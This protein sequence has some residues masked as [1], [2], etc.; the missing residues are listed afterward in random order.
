MRYVYP[1]FNPGYDLGIVRLG[2]PGLGNLLIFYA[3]AIVYAHENDARII[4]PTWP[5]IK[6]GPYIRREKDKRFYGDLFRHKDDEISGL[7]KLFLLLFSRKNITMCDRYM[8]TMKEAGL[9]GKSAMIYSHLIKHNA[10]PEYMRN[11]RG[12]IAV[13]VRLGDFLRVSEAALKNNAE[14]SSTPVYWYADTINKIRA[15]LG[16]N[17]QV[18]VFSDG[19]DEE[20]K[21]LLELEN[22]ERIFC[23]NALNDIL[24]IATASLLIGSGSTFSNWARY[25]GNMSAIYFPG[26]LREKFMNNNNENGF[27]I[28]LDNDEDFSAD[29]IRKLRLKFDSFSH[30]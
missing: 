2:G 11:I 26:Q 29:I 28:E 14:N 4:Y 15:V 5:S 17:I 27:E 10:H 1:K 19:T 12:S 18:Y 30:I 24:T 25:L 16:N 20:L 7:K 13:H 23:G 22:C 8:L 21:P 3:Q 9:L 6:L